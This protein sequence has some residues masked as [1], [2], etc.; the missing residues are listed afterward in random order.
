MSTLASLVYNENMI[1][2]EDIIRD[3]DPILRAQAKPV[4]FPLDPNTLEL[5]R[6][7]LEFLEVSQ[8]KE[9]NETYHLRPGVGLA[10]P[11][12]DHSLQMTALLIPAI[13][14]EE[15]TEPF[16]KGIVFNPRITRESVKRAALEAGE[17]CLSKDEDVPGIVLRADKITV[18]YDDEKGQHCSIRLKD[19]PAI[20][21]QHEI[22][23]LRGVM[24]YDHINEL[25]PWAVADD[26]VLIK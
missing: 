23:H 26:V 25:D 20:V 13:K 14:P 5:G 15:S 12:V 10:G 7:M 21:F 9:K 16:F 17:G 6:R 2:M 18:D 19:Y 11:Q 3:G 4:V 1:L 8:D 24:Y 22:D